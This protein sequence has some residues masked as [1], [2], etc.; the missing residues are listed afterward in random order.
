MFLK[1]N[2]RR[3]RFSGSLPRGRKKEGFWDF[4]RPMQNRPIKEHASAVH[5]KCPL[6]S[7]WRGI[8]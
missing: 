6:S 4:M 2:L 3:E 1:A 7:I 5:N 8:R